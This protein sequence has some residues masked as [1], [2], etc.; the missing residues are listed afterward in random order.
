MQESVWLMASRASDGNTLSGAY[1]DLPY[2]RC[3]H[4]ATTGGRMERAVVGSF[5]SYAAASQVA[6]DLMLAGF[7]QSEINIVG[8]GSVRAGDAEGHGELFGQEPHGREGT[9]FAGSPDEGMIAV[10]SIADEL[11]RAGEGG[12]L[13]QL[14]HG[15][16]SMGVENCA[17]MRHAR[18]VAR[19]GA[20]IALRLAQSRV[21]LAEAVIHRHSAEARIAHRQDPG[22]A[23]R[24]PRCVT[25]RVVE[26]GLGLPSEALEAAPN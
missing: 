22:P 5:A 11:L 20:L 13:P 17:A 24:Q 10:G 12:L 15:L 14:A 9:R 8:Q 6:A 26:T 23:M 1:R 21:A 4:A 25:A 2:F 7:A 18:A 19:G 3:C 16:A